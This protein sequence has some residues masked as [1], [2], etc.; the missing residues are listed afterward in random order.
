VIVDVDLRELERAAACGGVAERAAL[1]RAQVRIGEAD[2]AL[3]RALAYCGEK[4]ERI[5][6]GYEGTCE[7]CNEPLGMLDLSKDCG[8]ALEAWVKP[9]PDL[10]EGIKLVKQRRPDDDWLRV[11][12]AYAIAMAC[13]HTWSVEGAAW[14]S[15]GIHPPYDVAL[16]RQHLEQIERLLRWP[17]FRNRTLILNSCPA[18]SSGLHFNWLPCDQE[19]N[20]ADKVWLAR[21]LQGAVEFKMS[22]ETL[23]KILVTALR[24]V[25]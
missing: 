5:A 2:D 9:L 19:A 17:D 14:N 11:K 10:L 16:L 23:R 8:T 1:L 22:R 3:V 7:W 6:L 21:R 15:G 4:V 20:F 24:E 25:T 13:F 12:V 18:P